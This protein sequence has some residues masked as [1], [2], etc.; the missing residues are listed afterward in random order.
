MINLILLLINYNDFKVFIEI[1]ENSSLYNEWSKRV[2]YPMLLWG[3]KEVIL[4]M[5]LPLYHK[6]RI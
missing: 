2:N 5:Y 1:D 4:I 6:H 3:S